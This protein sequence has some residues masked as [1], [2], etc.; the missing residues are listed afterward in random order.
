ML[1]FRGGPSHTFSTTTSCI[2]HEIILCETFM[3]M[4]AVWALHALP[5]QLR[6][7]GNTC[8]SYSQCEQYLLHNH[9]SEQ[10]SHFYS[11]NMLVRSCYVATHTVSFPDCFREKTVRLLWIANTPWQLQEWVQLQSDC[12]N[13]NYDSMND[14]E[15]GKSKFNN[16]QRSTFQI[17]A[18]VFCD[19][20]TILSNEN[21][22]KQIA[23]YKR[24]AAT[25]AI[26]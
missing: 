12:R 5:L 23:S 10:S 20:V 14:W 13:G 18:K 2:I 16:Q 6:G 22:L 19:Y 9:V 26:L 7:H 8:A 3:A 25:V 15:Q 1:L 11:R 21:T 4:K 24:A 17:S